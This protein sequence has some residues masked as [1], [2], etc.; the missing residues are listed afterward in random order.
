M[1]R[2]VLKLIVSSVAAATATFANAQSTGTPMLE[3]VVVTAQKREQSLGDTPLSLQAFQG[4]DLETSGISDIAIFLKEIPSATMANNVGAGAV[5]VV[6]LR[7]SGGLAQSGDGAVA[8][9]LD[10]VPFGI[11]NLQFAPI[12]N[13]YDLERVE[14]LRGP[15][16]TI[17]GQGS[18]GG[19][20]RYLANDPQLD[21]VDFKAQASYGNVEDGD[22]SYKVNAAV[23]I[24]IVEDVFGL[25][26]AAGTETRSGYA[27]SPDVPGED[28]NEIETEFVRVKALW[29]VSD[30]LS[31]E[32][33]YWHMETEQGFNNLLT[34]LEPPTLPASGGESGSTAG[35]S[36]VYSLSF[37][38]SLEHFDVVATSG[39]LEHY[40]PLL[41][42]FEQPGVGNV[43]AEQTYDTETFSQE[44]RLVSN[45][46]GPVNWIVGGYYSDTEQTQRQDQ[47]F[48]N[49]FLQALV[50]TDSVQDIDSEV[51]AAFGEISYSMMDG[52]LV[53]LVG[54]R[55]F[56]DDRSLVDNSLRA[57][58]IDEGDI[59]VLNFILEQLAGFNPGFTECSQLP[60]V[61]LSCET[62][63]PEF[64]TDETFDSVNPRFNLSYYPSDDSMFYFN[65]AKGFRSGYVQTQAAVSAAA[66]D[67]IETSVG[68]DNDSVWTYEVGGKMTLLEGRLYT[69]FAAYRAEYEDAQ[70]L[71]S[72]LSGF[73]AGVQG[74][75]YRVDGLE[76][77]VD[78]TPVAGL[79]LSG[80]Y[81]VTDS[82]W[83][84][85][86]PSVA[87]AV[88]GVSDGGSVPFIPESD[89]NVSVNY[90]GQLFDT[91]LQHFEYLGYSRTSEQ[92][93]YSLLESE[94]IK[95]LS[96][97]IGVRSDH[98]QAALYGFN[99]T[100]ERGPALL[101][102]GGIISQYP[103]EI[104]LSVQY[105]FR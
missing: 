10:E 35:E 62:Q 53:P 2:R 27:E 22:D 32:A 81:S 74:G 86:D 11:L 41:L 58:G 102:G 80:F 1:N 42:T 94:P 61:G 6:H 20:L 43:R 69:E 93:T 57:K 59:P 50:G 8:Y 73:P 55:Y 63:A 77:S 39:W 17:W 89:Y 24:P 30:D 46:D 97:R 60:L 5:Q 104:G 23:N 28:I 18:M 40:V 71:Y 66:L 44:L 75:D 98:W 37:N 85:V 19:T 101:N 51:Y 34:N 14:V 87:N 79:T 12:A 99:L 33:M 47:F 3:E 95:D 92:V 21:E 83:T 36:D 9:Y 65:A 25:R 68:L 48:F 15:Q 26:I 56:S 82:E 52:K 16:G 70:I 4:D 72:T 7:G 78:Y 105:N 90:E 84:K 54:V 88:P 31:V 13:M 100:D 29:D 67:G 45:G 76:I 64:S 103:R 49:P 91:N 96:M 38:W